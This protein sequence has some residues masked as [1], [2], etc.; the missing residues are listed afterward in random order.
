MLIFI[1]FVTLCAISCS[2]YYKCCLINRFSII[3][4]VVY[5]IL[6]CKMKHIAFDFFLQLKF[7]K[8]SLHH[9][10]IHVYV[11]C[12]SHCLCV[13]VYAYIYI[14]IYIYMCVC[15]CVCDEGV[16][17][18]LYNIIPYNILFHMCIERSLIQK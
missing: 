17:R 13:V 6:S 8:G 4:C 7:L 14:Y 2:K 10:V 11:Y 9:F 15:V 16:P 1:V 18:L 3:M 5:D 12:I